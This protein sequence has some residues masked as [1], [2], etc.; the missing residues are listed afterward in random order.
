MNSDHVWPTL[1]HELT[2]VESYQSGQAQISTWTR[3][4]LRT[5]GRQPMFTAGRRPA[6]ET[7]EPARRSG[8]PQKKHKKYLQIERCVQVH[9]YV[10]S[11]LLKTYKFLLINHC[12]LLLMVHAHHC[13]PYLSTTAPKT[14]TCQ[15]KNSLFLFCLS[16]FVEKLPPAKKKVFFAPNLP[17]SKKKKIRHRANKTPVP[18]NTP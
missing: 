12:S 14:M 13:Y 16:F 11:T 5:G 15:K 6:S 7:P 17:A 9:V 1:S 8:W 3:P 18:L 2:R 10:Y 4:G